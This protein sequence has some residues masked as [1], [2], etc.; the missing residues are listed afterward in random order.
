M[1]QGYAEWL[2]C[3]SLKCGATVGI[4]KWTLELIEK[5]RTFLVLETKR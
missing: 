5:N 2:L 1:G 4:L 3:Q